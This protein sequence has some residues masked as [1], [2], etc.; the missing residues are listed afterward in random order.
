MTRS[1]RKKEAGG[2]WRYH[3]YVF[4]QVTGFHIYDKLESLRPKGFGSGPSLS[5][6]LVEVSFRVPDLLLGETKPLWCFSFY[7]IHVNYCN[8]V[9]GFHQTKSECFSW[10]R[11]YF[12]SKR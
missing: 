10:R 1:Y 9:P 8:F 12:G 6:K 7:L 3:L 4:R 2:G 11:E 5:I